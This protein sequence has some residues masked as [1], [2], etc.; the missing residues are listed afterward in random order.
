[1]IVRPSE[2]RDIYRLEIQDGQQASIDGLGDDFD[3][4]VCADLGLAQ[5]AEHDGQVI[6]MWG[7]EE[8][9]ANRMIVWAL[10]SRHAGPLMPVIHRHAVRFLASLDARRLETYVDVGFMP[11]HR[12]IKM[13]GFEVEGYMKAFRAT[14]EDM[15]M[16]ARVR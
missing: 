7:A 4:S 8:A 5:T 11:G 1:M 6:A 15:V 14:G 9:W 10:I 2:N 13:L 3:L 16:Y 12:W